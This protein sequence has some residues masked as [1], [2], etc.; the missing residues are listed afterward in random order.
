[1][2]RIFGLTWTLMCMT[3]AIHAEPAK[4]F[5]E[6]KGAGPSTQVAK[7]F[8]EQLAS[9]DAASGYTFNVEERSSKHAGGVRAS[10]IFLFGRTGRPLSPEERALGK[11]DLFLASLPVGFVV[12]PSVGLN[13]LSI[14]Q[15]KSIFCRQVDSW[16]ELGG[17]DEAIFRV[18]REPQEAAL[19]VLKVSYPFLDNARYDSTLK[20]NHAVIN[21]LQAPPGRYAIAYGPL[22]NFDT[23]LRV[24]IEGD[25]PSLPMGLVYDIS[26]RDHPLV[27]AARRFAQS[28]QWKSSVKQ[29][30]LTTT[31]LQPSP[32]NA[33]SAATVC[34]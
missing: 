8:F 33:V 24:S 18:G 28:K 19:S 10:S 6:V 15:V 21:L 23:A 27:K 25:Q 26:N 11:E 22:P 30:G 5:Q 31:N 34:G 17:P 1:M 4:L 20:R 2:K 3:P 32:S 29:L 9:L 13:K 14:D 16:S 7:L 12:G